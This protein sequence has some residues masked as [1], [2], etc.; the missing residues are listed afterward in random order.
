MFG[1]LD[2]LGLGNFAPTTAAFKF[3]GTVPDEHIPGT[4]NVGYALPT[5]LQAF[6]YIAVVEVDPLTLVLMIAAAVLGAWLGAGLVARWPRRRV[7][8][9]MGCA[10]LAAA[11]LLFRQLRQGDPT[12]GEELALMGPRLWVGLAGNFA[13]GALMTLG[14]G[15]YAPCLILV[16]LL[17]MNP[18]AAFPIMMGS[19]AFLMP[20]GGVRFI[21]AGSYS[22]SAAIVLTVASLPAV[23]IAWYFIYE[24]KL[25]MLRWLVLVVV[26]WTA[27]LML[28]SAF[29]REDRT[30]NAAPGTPP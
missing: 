1:F 15:L 7:Q 24:M 8:F 12:G 14:V 23:V 17:G 28:R 3:R 29:V 30:Q 22:P 16:S 25:G 20:V 6:L 11:V 2:T 26:L 10:L 5:I 4:L 19:C 27:V 18:R 21:R 13:L 9:G